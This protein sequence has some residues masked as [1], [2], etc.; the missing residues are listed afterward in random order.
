MRIVLYILSVLIITACTKNP[1]Q[2]STDN[3][4]VTSTNP[5]SIQSWRLSG[6]AGG[7][8]KHKSWSALMEWSQMG[9]DNYDIYLHG[10][11]GTNTVSIKRHGSHVVLNDGKETITATREDTLIAHRTGLHIPIHALYYWVRGIPV[12]N[13]PSRI[14][15]DSAHHITTL[16]QLGYAIHYS[17]YTQAHGVTLPSKLSIEGTNLKL[18][19]VIKHWDING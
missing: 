10:P 15:E 7:H 6:I 14:S 3:T 9:I 17:E 5:A 13:V 11:M 1:P 19:F 18:K 12:P 8:Y 2:V 16:S 4:H